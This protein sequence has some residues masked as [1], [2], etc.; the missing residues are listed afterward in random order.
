[1]ADL[2]QQT[3]Q[4]EPLQEAANA[5]SIPSREQRTKAACG[6]PNQRMLSAQ[7][8]LQ[9]SFVLFQ[10]GI[11]TP[12]AAALLV[13]RWTAQ[14]CGLA[15]TDSV[16]LHVGQPLAIPFDSGLHELRQIPQ[17]VDTL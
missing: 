9:H 5:T 8:N 4:T 12:V 6:H 11:E 10:K 3:V 2:P 14:P 15:L 1:M 16:L 17:T 13:V 7:E